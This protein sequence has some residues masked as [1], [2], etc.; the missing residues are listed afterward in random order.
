LKS[1][2]ASL[3]K[4]VKNDD[5]SAIRQIFFRLVDGYT[6]DEEM[7]DWLLMSQKHATDRLPALPTHGAPDSSPPAKFGT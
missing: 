5:Y 4:A 3:E 6:P 7:V 1:E 2:L